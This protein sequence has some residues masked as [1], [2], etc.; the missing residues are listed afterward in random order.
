VSLFRVKGSPTIYELVG[1]SVHAYPQPSY[2]GPSGPPN[3]GPEYIPPANKAYTV[4]TIADLPGKITPWPSDGTYLAM[5][6][7]VYG[8]NQVPGQTPVYW[9]NGTSYHWIPNSQIFNDSG[10]QW[11]NVHEVTTIAH[12]PIGSPMMLFRQ[13]GHTQVYLLSQGQLHWIPSA[14]DFTSL[15]YRWNEVWTVNELPAPIGFPA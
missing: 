6:R 10:F 12:A 4:P 5:T 9:F 13:Q 11:S 8:L 2:Y 1:T 7:T 15:D 14:A 3:S